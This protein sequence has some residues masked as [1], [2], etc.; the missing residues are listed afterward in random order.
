MGILLYCM[1][2]K[3]SQAWD[4]WNVYPMV[5]ALYSCMYTGLAMER[6]SQPVTLHSTHTSTVTCM[7]RY[8]F[9]LP[10]ME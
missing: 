2:M 1:H 10:H 4:G 7:T 5:H 3:P 8:P 9:R 6:A